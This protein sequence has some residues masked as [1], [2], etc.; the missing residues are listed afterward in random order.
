M[1]RGQVL[2]GLMLMSL[3]QIFPPHEIR[4]VTDEKTEAQRVAWSHPVNEQENL[5]PPAVSCLQQQRVR[6][7]EDA[8]T[9]QSWLV[10]PTSPISL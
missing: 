7:R 2:W 5:I 6:D 3:G 4:I 8:A 10:T 1:L 9:L